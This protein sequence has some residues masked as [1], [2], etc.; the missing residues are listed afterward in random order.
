MQA[1]ARPTP[2]LD[3]Y[4]VPGH[5]GLPPFLQ[6]PG[7]PIGIPHLQDVPPPDVGPDELDRRHVPGHENPPRR[8]C[9]LGGSCVILDTRDEAPKTMPITHPHKIRSVQARHSPG[10]IF[11]PPFHL[12]P[13]DK[14]PPTPSP[15]PRDALSYLPRHSSSHGRSRRVTAAREI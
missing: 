10:G 5:G 12:D 9:G 11:R 4:H 15:L 14:L 2:S 3:L 1:M 6:G 13:K 7:G 8:G